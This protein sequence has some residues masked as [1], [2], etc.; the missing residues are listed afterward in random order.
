MSVSGPRD[1]YAEALKALLLGSDTTVVVVRSGGFDNP[2]SLMQDLARLID[3]HRDHLAAFFSQRPAI[4]GRIGLVLLARSELRI[5]QSSSPVIWP[6]WVPGVGGRE[7]S[8]FIQ[9]I[10]R[11]VDVAL[12]SSE[13]GLERLSRSIYDLEWALARRLKT[14]NKV[15]PH[16]QT[17]MWDMI[18]GNQDH[19][20]MDGFL[21]SVTRA[22]SSEGTVESYRPTG[23]G[24]RSLCGRLWVRMQM[25]EPRA[26]APL[27]KAVATAL[28]LE[29]LEIDTPPSQTLFSVLSRSGPSAQDASRGEQFAR[30][31]L[32]TNANACQ[33]ITCAAHAGDYGR[34]PLGL[35]QGVAD[36]LH[37]GITGFESFINTLPR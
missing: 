22:L 17:I 26:V 2:N 27:A 1:E 15:R 3:S 36:E 21:E 5:P 25:R 12:D 32:V 24:A 11:S 35:L 34:Y 19:A 37:R 4:P 9:D 29:D 10:T 31:I 13:L 16:A 23:R 28:G 6:E 7:I 18:R 14:I 33:L 8:C 20:G 30:D